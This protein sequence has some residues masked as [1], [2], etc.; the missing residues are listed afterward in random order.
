ME[1][2]AKIQHPFKMKIFNILEIEGIYLNIVKA[3][4]EKQ[5]RNIIVNAKS[6]TFLSE[7]VNYVRMPI[8]TS[9]VQ[10]FAIKFLKKI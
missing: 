5:T 3:I 7:T 1:K 2:F 4:Y 9:S 8:F 6:E 10:H